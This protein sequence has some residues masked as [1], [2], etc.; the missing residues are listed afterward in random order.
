MNIHKEPD[1]LLLLALAI[2]VV[3]GLK[4]FSSLYGYH[5]AATHTDRTVENYQRLFKSLN[6]IAFIQV[7]VTIAVY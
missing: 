4:L 5:L 2:V 6:V 1:V 3:S 7:I